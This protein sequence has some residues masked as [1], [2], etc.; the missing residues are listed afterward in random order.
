M[1]FLVLRLEEA[2]KKEDRTEHFDVLTHSHIIDIST[3]TYRIFYFVGSMP[4]FADQK[5]IFCTFF[6]FTR[7]NE[8]KE[9]K[10]NKC[11]FMHEAYT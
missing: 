11:A 8:K 5:V 4:L 6:G 7:W 3:T 9:V 1:K 10:K 2:E